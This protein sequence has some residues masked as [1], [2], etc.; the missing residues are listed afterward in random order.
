MNGGKWR[1][2]EAKVRN[3]GS[4]VTN[5]YF[6]PNSFNDR[7]QVTEKRELDS[8]AQQFYLF[9]AKNGIGHH[10]KVILLLIIGQNRKGALLMIDR[11]VRIQN[12]VCHSCEKKT[13]FDMTLLK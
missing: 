11:S 9:V 5:S 1:N 3:A 12:E 8:S 4:A 10:M 6:P 13:T 2:E 7:K